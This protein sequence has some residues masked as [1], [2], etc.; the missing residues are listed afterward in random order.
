[1]ILVIDYGMVMLNWIS[2]V[3]YIYIF[4]DFGCIC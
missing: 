3:I 2:W 1:M 4:I